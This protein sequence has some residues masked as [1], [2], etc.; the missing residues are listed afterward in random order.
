MRVAWRAPAGADQP[1]V[2]GPG[3]RGAPIVGRILY[4]VAVIAVACLLVVAL[5]LLLERLD[6]GTV[7][8]QQ[9]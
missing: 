1:E 2:S 9:L 5:L 4:W 7:A 3:R 6:Q 8:L